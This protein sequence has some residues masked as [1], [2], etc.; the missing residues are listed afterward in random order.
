MA[1]CPEC[2]AGRLV[3]DHARGEVH[4]AQCGIVVEEN[5]ID[6]GAEWR[7]FDADQRRD[8]ERVGA[9]LTVM[10]HDLGLG[11]VM[12]GRTDAHGKAI[13]GSDMGR[14]RRLQ[15]W[16]RRARF[17]R[18]AERNLAQALAEIKRMGSALD[19]PKSVMEGAAVIYREAA[20]KNLIRGRSIDSVA[21]ASI[22]AA[23]RD[24][25]VPRSLEEVAEVSRTKKREIGRVYKVVAA[26]LSLNLKPVSPAS[27]IPRFASRLRLGNVSEMRAM[28]LVQRAVE[29]E[30]VSG[31]DPKSV[32]A[33]AIYIASVLAG[34][35]RTQKDVSEA[36]GV[37]EVTIRNR[38]KELIDALKLD[39]DFG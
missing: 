18:G 33:G 13:S 19:V 6:A 11:T 15:K 37:T 27:F 24:N 10:Q 36:S 23:M 5:M 20:V 34:E 39:F 26:E 8:K 1:A 12:W 17:K 21:A 35:P 30:V 14:I 4:C 9:P 3:H 2:G 32:A 38:Y 25:G 31:K 16:D 22:Y 28:E 7:A 29:A